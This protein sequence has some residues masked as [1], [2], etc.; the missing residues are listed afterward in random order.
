MSNCIIIKPGFSTT[1][2]AKNT[3]N[4]DKEF[5]NYARAWLWKVTWE[6]KRPKKRQLLKL[7]DLRIIIL[8]KVRHYFLGT[9]M[10]LGDL[11][12]RVKICDP[13][14]IYSEI[15]WFLD[16]KKRKRRWGDEND[17]VLLQ[18][19][20]LLPTPGVL[21]S[22]SLKN[23]GRSNPEL[24]Q[25]AIR[26]FGTTDLTESQWKQCEDQIKVKCLY[27]YIMQ[28]RRGIQIIDFK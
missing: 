20:V 5:R 19:P 7:R 18:A 15:W 23:V 28:I 14:S 12:L 2:A 17:K 3:E 11:R 10:V 22:G 9:A 4:I 25:Y 1:R 21:P 27:R 13:W 26:V 24:I 16:P 8:V 6:K